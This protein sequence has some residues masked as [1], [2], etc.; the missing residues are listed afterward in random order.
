M[1]TIS[2]RH[3]SVILPRNIAH[4]VL[5]VIPT[6]RG[7]VADGKEL[8]IVP[9]RLE[10]TKVLRNLGFEV[11]NPVLH[12]YDWPGQHEPFVAQKTT[13]DFLV[14]NT[15]AFCLNQMGTGKTISALWAY[16]YL[17]KQKQVNK[18]MVITPLSTLERTWG[19][20][21]FKSFMHKRFAVLHGTKSQ[22]LAL[23]ND[24]I[25]DIYLINHDGIKVAGFMEAMSKRDDIDLLIIDEIAEFRHGST[26]KWKILHNLC[27]K[28]G[29]RRVWGLTGTPTPDEPTDAWAQC[30]L[31]SPTSVPPYFSKF[32]D[33]TMR[34][35]STYKWVARDGALETVKMAMQPSINFTR[36]ECID[37]PPVVHETRHVDLDKEQQNAF[38]DMLVKLHYEYKNGVILARNEAIKINKLLQICCGVAYGEQGTEIHFGADARIKL[39]KEIVEQAGGKTIIFVPFTS[40]LN[41]V[42]KILGEK[43]DVAVVQGST[44]KSERNEIFK[45]FQTSESPKVIV[46]QPGTMS[47]GLTLTAANTIIWFSPIHSNNIFNQAI[48]RISRPGQKLSQLIVMIEGSK[49]EREIYNRL[50]TKT[51]L[52]GVLLNMLKTL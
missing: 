44:N 36:A 43:W 27:N 12:Y 17:H 37:L 41:N 10:E 23:L 24:P 8:I 47:H 50:L 39:V 32:R 35:V 9:H 11:P 29:K 15:R 20:E 25:Y 22:R 2:E 52:Q 45:Q 46:A 40:A 18:M 33:L 14:M 31:I 13:V 34:Q 28:Q 48:A 4:H 5:T 16:D 6:A 26:D 1:T 7:V 3:Q 51:K 21:I 30:K 49:I 19:D 42:A 38:R